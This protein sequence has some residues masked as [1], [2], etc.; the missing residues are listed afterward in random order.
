MVGSG[1]STEPGKQ[2]TLKAE[3]TTPSFP[4]GSEFLVPR[5]CSPSLPGRCPQAPPSQS[6]PDR[7]TVHSVPPQHPNH[8]L[9][10]PSLEGVPSLSSPA[11]SS[12]TTPSR[13]VTGLLTRTRCVYKSLVTALHTQANLPLS[14]FSL[15]FFF[16]VEGART[17]PLFPN[18]N[19]GAQRR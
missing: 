18:R 8:C 9:S 3:L 10:F 16:L 15:F 4:Q 5:Q 14:F 13:R 1:A 2:V 6:H 19:S 17:K 11:L 7:I 12:L